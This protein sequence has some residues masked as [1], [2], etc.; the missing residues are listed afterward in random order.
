M[1]QAH[2]WEAN[3]IP[4]T[5]DSITS[6]DSRVNEASYPEVLT[7]KVAIQE[8]NHPRWLSTLGDSSRKLHRLE[9][10]RGQRLQFTGKC[11]D[12]CRFQGTLRMTLG[13]RLAVNN[14][15]RT[16]DY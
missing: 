2:E 12:T 7:P 10:F 11:I 3:E 8:E 14:C 9:R 5:L 4:R 6:D 16:V 13:F 1:I 15:E